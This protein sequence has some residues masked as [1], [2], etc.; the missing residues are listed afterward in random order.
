MQLQLL[1]VFGPELSTFCTLRLLL[2]LPLLLQ[3]LLRI[4]NL[5]SRRNAACKQ[6]P[7]ENANERGRGRSKRKCHFVATRRPCACVCECGT[8]LD[9][10]V[11]WAVSTLT[12]PSGHS[13][14]LCLPASLIC[15]SMAILSASTNCQMF[16]WSRLFVCFVYLFVC[17]FVLR[18]VSVAFCAVVLPSF[19]PQKTQ[20]F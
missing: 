13:P 2:L 16:I 20:I 3:L 17:S 5:F 6:N 8:T 7:A 15:P 18:A 19:S 10:R 9:K 12:P 4:F 14:S 1:A 11:K